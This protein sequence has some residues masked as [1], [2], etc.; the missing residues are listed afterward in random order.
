M[1]D[2]KRVK[3]LIIGTAGHVDHGKT[4][5]IRALTGIDADRLK[6]E[7]ER[8]MTID[9]GFAWLTLPTGE[10]VGIVDV[11]GHERF[12][13]NM[14]AGATG[15]DVA[16]L[17]VAADEGIMP[18]TREHL[19]ILRILDTKRGI[20]ALTKIDMVDEEWVALVEADVR[21]ELTGSFL[22]NARIVRVSAETG[23]GV[24]E[25]S[26]ALFAL[27]QESYARERSVAGGFR[28]PIDRIFTM[29]GFGTVVTG[30]LVSGTIRVGDAA[31][32]LPRGLG[33]RVR[34]LQVH[35]AKVEEVGA[36]T[37]VAVNLVG[38]E[39]E[40]LERGDVCAAPG[41]LKPSAIVDVHLALLP[42][43]PGPL[44]N[45]ARL[46]FYVGTSETIGRIVLLD[47][48][49]LLPGQSAFAQFRAERPLV[50]ANGDRFVVRSYSPMHTIGGG[51]VLDASGGGRKHR[52][53]DQAVIRA[54]QARLQGNPVEVA[55][56]VLRS[57]GV[58]TA[59]DLARSANWPQ[60]QAREALA[61]LSLDCRAVDLGN[62]QFVDAVAHEMLRDRIIRALGEYHQLHLSRAGLPKEDLSRAC[63]PGKA[64]AAALTALQREGKVALDGNLARLIEHS[65]RLTEA[66]EALAEEIASRYRRVKLDAPSEQEVM[67]SL[68]ESAAAAEVFQ[69]L[70]RTGELVK[71]EE[72]LY[73]H[74]DTIAAA[75]GLLRTHLA[76]HPT[77][78]V[79]E[80]RDLTGSSRKY[81]V[82]LL[83]YF[84]TKRIT[85]RV[86]DARVL[87]GQRAKP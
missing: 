33:T 79:S 58:T 80:F 15:V 83:E 37:R 18:Q 75:E 72:G 50:C 31:E 51:I 20:V 70:L 17:V 57:S 41:L 9:L 44:E 12:L 30:T 28:L 52:A 62:G 23:V 85:R 3:N 13:K 42:G 76:Q 63:G 29:T 24:A 87:L 61:A 74:R 21:A 77:M 68:P 54:L 11:P 56:D 14:L 53:G 64:F 2:E 60:D 7:K 1:A 59:Q 36:G 25:L 4:T 6:E 73:L 38:L 45:R 19:D 10:K 8:G 78:T 69:W 86:G 81:V 47:T 39:V 65:P 46:R 16:L 43:A 40:E 71:I 49:K 5:L 82:P 26:D 67:Q 32:I 66:Q 22:E 55:A 35:G 48:D 34:Q 84:D 27:C